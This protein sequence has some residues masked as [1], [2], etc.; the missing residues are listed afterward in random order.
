[1]G[2]QAILMIGVV[3]VLTGAIPALSTGRSWGYV[4]RGVL[5]LVMVVLVLVFSIGRQ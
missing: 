1:M 5:G 3:L 4:P 2:L